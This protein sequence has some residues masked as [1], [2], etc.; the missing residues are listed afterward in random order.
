[1][2][3]HALYERLCTAP[4][5]RLSCYGALEV[6]VTLLLLLLSL[7]VQCIVIGPV[8]V[9]VCLLV[10]GSIGE[11]SDHLQ[12]IKFLAL[13]GRGSKMFGSALLQ[14]ACSVCVS[15]SA[16][17][18]VVAVAVAAGV[19]CGDNTDTRSEAIF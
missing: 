2:L 10:G 1:M 14:P 15:L 7:A 11:G 9:C 6:I 13:P 19:C 17:F 8:C 12:L 3:L 4:L 5:N 16:F 18:I